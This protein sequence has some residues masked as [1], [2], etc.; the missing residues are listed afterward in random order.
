M[1][2]N[3][4]QEPVGPVYT[5]T[6]PQFY[7]TYY[8]FVKITLLGPLTGKRVTWVRAQRTRQDFAYMIQEVVDVHS[9][10]AEKLVLVMDNL[11]TQTIGSLYETFQP[12]E[13]HRLSQKLEIPHTPTYASWLNIAEIELAVLA[14]Q[15]LDRRVASL[16]E[17]QREVTAWQE[18][19]NQAL[20]GID[21]CFTTSDARIK[22]KRLYP[23][24]K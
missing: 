1:V 15:C 4:L 11:N 16:E 19:H 3:S 24:V 6:Q 10:D 17:A 23:T 8:F 21:W 13:A 20:R 14:G 2:F 7:G 18:A 5:L 22:L 9:P 12:E